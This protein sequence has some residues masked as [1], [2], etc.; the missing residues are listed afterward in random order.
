MPAAADTPNDP[1][2]ALR[3]SP[4]LQVCRYSLVFISSVSAGSAQLREAAQLAK[5]TSSKVSISY[6]QRDNGVCLVSSITPSTGSD[7]ALPPAPSSFDAA[8]ALPG[9]IDKHATAFKAAY[10]DFGQNKLDEKVDPISGKLTLTHV[11]VA[12]PGPNGMDIRV[13]RQYVSPDPEQVAS[14]IIQS[15]ASQIYGVGWDIVVGSGGVRNNY[16]ACPQASGD[17]PPLDLRALP[18]WIDENGNAEAMV[19]SPPLGWVAASGARLNC[20]TSPSVTTPDGKT[21]DLMF[22]YR[23]FADPD[24]PYRALPTKITDRWGNW[25]TF[26]Y[27]MAYV[28]AIDGADVGVFGQQYSKLLPLKKVTASDGRVVFFDYYSKAP[29]WT[30]AS[31]TNF[32]DW[33]LQRIRYGSYSVLYD[34][35]R[36]SP[37]G[38]YP[39]YWLTNIT[40]GDGKNWAFDYNYPAFTG[41]GEA[42]SPPVGV[43][44]INSM[45]LPDG[46][47]NTYAW[48]QSLRYGPRYQCGGILGGTVA[49]FNTNQI[50]QKTTSDGGA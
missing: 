29:G 7:D 8:N 27:D 15:V 6:S 24:T 47:I 31:G 25:L 21:I 50:R 37:L 14:S 10:R 43:A 18:Q 41:I 22:D 13:V 45:T 1:Y 34:Y 4:P 19:P 32:Y 35:A 5:A 49:T 28:S 20:L 46:G 2:Y 42:C 33:G 23:A 39:K 9:Y 26:E 17:G 38:G 30:P 36:L 12:I 16:R 40:M 44:A 48:G 11:D 3:V